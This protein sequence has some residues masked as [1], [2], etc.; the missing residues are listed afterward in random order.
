[1]KSTPFEYTLVGV[2]AEM[3][4]PDCFQIRARPVGPSHQCVIQK[5]LFRMHE[6]ADAEF[7][8]RVLKEAAI[9]VEPKSV[10]TT[11]AILCRYDQPYIPN[12]EIHDKR[13]NFIR[14]M[15]SI[16]KHDPSQV[17]RVKALGNL[18][19]MLVA[20][21]KRDKAACKVAQ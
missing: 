11:V 6:E 1:M 4:C 12:V 3:T 10:R 5:T 20:E 7:W 18:V 14:F 2:N 8:Q 17:V 13:E 21:D 15:L 16:A 19:D 9:M